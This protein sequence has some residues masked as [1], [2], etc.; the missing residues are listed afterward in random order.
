MRCCELPVQP[1]TLGLVLA[2]AAG[3]LLGEW[4][5]AQAQDELLAELRTVGA[6]EWEQAVADAERTL[7]ETSS[8]GE[9]K[10]RP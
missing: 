7:Q 4:F 10:E 2:V 3:V 9:R 1:V 8:A 6:D 5:F